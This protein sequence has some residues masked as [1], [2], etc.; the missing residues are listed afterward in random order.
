MLLLQPSESDILTRFYFC[1]KKQFFY[2]SAFLIWRHAH[3]QFV[4]RWPL[5]L[6]YIFM[7]MSLASQPR[8]HVYS[9]LSPPAFDVAGLLTTGP[10]NHHYVH[11]DY[12]TSLITSSLSGTP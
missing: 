8:G 6:I 2:Q 9:R 3:A 11:L 7:R 10:G 12:I 4:A 5:D 1:K